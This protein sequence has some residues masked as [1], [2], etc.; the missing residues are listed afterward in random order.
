[1]AS[2][3]LG[4]P[5]SASFRRYHLEHHTYQGVDELDPDLPLAWE[6]RL[7]RGNMFAKI[8]WLAIYPAMYIVRGAAMMKTPSAWEIFNWVLVVSS[9]IAIYTFLGVDAFKYIALSTYFGYTFHPIAAHFIQEHFTFVDGQETFSYYGP[10]NLLTL[11]IGYHQE[12]HDFPSI[13]W[14]GLP[15]VRRIAAKFYDPLKHWDSWSGLFLSFIADP[16]IGPVSRL[17]RTHDAHKTGRR[18]VTR[19]TSKAAGVTAD[20]IGDPQASQ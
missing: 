17:A 4:L 16:S 8:L 18:M 5:I 1:M 7:I 2:V 20:E 14:S 3:A 19:A 12:H 11:N 9:N 6:V 10:G 13:P 15:E